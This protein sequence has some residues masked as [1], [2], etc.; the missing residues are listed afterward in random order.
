MVCVW[1][2]SP[3]S[4]EFGVVVAVVTNW[5]IGET[6]IVVAYYM[7]FICINT[8]CSSSFAGTSTKTCLSNCAI[9][10]S[11]M[12]SYAVS[13]PLIYVGALEWTSWASPLRPTSY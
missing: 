2:L 3:S 5:I 6:S 11:F 13:P 4:C 12:A 9:V 7:N 8:C 10:Y 1:P